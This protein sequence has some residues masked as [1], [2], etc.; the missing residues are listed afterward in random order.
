MHVIY[1]LSTAIKKRNT[2]FSQEIALTDEQIRMLDRYITKFRAADPNLRERIVEEAADSIENTW[3]ED[4]EFDRDAVT[5]V[6]ESSVT[7]N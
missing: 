2:C 6:R 5:N 4:P 3:A 7:V 1:L